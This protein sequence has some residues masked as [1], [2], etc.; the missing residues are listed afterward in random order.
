MSR[1]VKIIIMASEEGTIMNHD[2]A[3][4]AGCKN[5]GEKIKVAPPLVCLYMCSILK[6]EGYY[7]ELIDTN[8]NK[9]LWS[10]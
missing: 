2:V 8:I 3:G 6:Q 10:K 7:V 5:I 9:E 4:G 1:I